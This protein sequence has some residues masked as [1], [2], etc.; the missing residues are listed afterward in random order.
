MKLAKD[1]HL[2]ST[3][4]NSNESRFSAMEN[5][6]HQNELKDQL[7]FGEVNSLIKRSMICANSNS[8]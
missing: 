6:V 3:E 8:L 1:P 4:K 2:P 7:I 5:A